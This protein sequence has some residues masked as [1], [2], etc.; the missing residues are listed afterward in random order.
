MT[1]LPSGI[2]FFVNMKA[3][4]VD[5]GAHTYINHM[6]DTKLLDCLPVSLWTQDL[7]VEAV[8]CPCGVFVALLQ[9][10]VTSS[11]DLTCSHEVTV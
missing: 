9:I 11:L 10:L 4:L 7:F 1:A 3:N 2:S 5:F 8:I 6:I